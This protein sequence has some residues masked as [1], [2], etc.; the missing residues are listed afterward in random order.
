M[1]AGSGVA[2]RLVTCAAVSVARIAKVT[3]AKAKA[4]RAILLRLLICVP[5]SRAISAAHLPGSLLAQ[6]GDL[7]LDLGVLRVNLRLLLLEEPG[8]VGLEL[9]LGPMSCLL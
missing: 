9:G 5:L 1:P 7:G 6:A 4:T 2:V 3:S 8:A